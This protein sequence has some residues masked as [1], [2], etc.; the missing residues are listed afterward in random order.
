AAL[1]QRPRLA[2]RLLPRVPAI[3]KQI[4]QLAEQMKVPFA[5]PEEDGRALEDDDLEPLFAQM[6]C[7]SGDAAIR[8]AGCLL[9]L[10][11]PRAIGALL[12]LTR[13]ADPALRRG[14]T[15]NLVLAVATWPD[16]DRL[17]ARLVW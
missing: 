7:R 5:V 9:A 3:Q 6:A 12:Q 10:G 16:D 2:A 14:A 4:E 15:S 17:T 1:L 8:G 13:E 11:D